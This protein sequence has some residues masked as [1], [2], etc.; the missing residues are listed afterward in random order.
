[1]T[2]AD[3]AAILQAIARGESKVRFPDGREVTYRT[4]GEL[5]DALALVRAEQAAPA[6][7]TTLGSFR[8]DP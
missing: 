1:M 4:V 3:E 5:R 2:P 8:K 6:N 7:R